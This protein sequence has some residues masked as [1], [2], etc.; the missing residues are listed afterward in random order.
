MRD[1]GRRN[2][3]RHGTRLRNIQSLGRYMTIDECCY[4]KSQ[5]LD[6]C[7][8]PAAQHDASQ[9]E[10]SVR[11]EFPTDVKSLGRQVS[12]TARVVARLAV[13]VSAVDATGAA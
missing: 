2:P 6:M 11:R 8:S 13:P 10:V 7:P 5:L 9:H 1:P 4:R 12:A 3:G